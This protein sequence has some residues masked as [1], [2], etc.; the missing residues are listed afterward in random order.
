MDWDRFGKINITFYSGRKKNSQKVFC[1][2]FMSFYPF[3]LIFYGEY[4]IYTN[5]IGYSEISHFNLQTEYFHKK[6]YFQLFI[7]CYFGGVMSKIE[8]EQNWRYG[9]VLYEPLQSQRTFI[10]LSNF[11]IVLFLGCDVEN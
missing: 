4:M 2:N 7:K 1:S 3:E 5:F 9:Y 10:F 8:F 6:V 11:E